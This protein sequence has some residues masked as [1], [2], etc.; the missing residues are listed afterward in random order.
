MKKGT[1][2]VKAK[3]HGSSFMPMEVTLSEEKIE[4]IKVDAK[5]ETKGVADEVFHRLPNQMLK[6]KL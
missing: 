1:Y 2:K 3:G 5:G 4:A 6:T